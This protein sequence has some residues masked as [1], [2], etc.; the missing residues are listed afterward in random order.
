MSNYVKFDQFK[1]FINKIANKFK[2]TVET[3]KIGNSTYTPSDGLVTLPDY[4]TASG[5][6]TGIK[7]GI[8]TYTPSE[9]VITIPAYPTSL[10]ASDVFSWA[11]QS[12]KPSYTASEVGAVSSVKIGTNTYSPNSNGLVTLPTYPSSLP[13]SDVYSWAKQSTKP[14]YTATEV[15]AVSKVTVNGTTYSATNG[16]VTLPNYPTGT[17]GVTSV[18]VG[19][20][21]YEPSDGVVSLPAYPSVPTKVS[22]LQNDS[23]FTTNAGTVT[24]VKVGNTSYN[25]S[26]GVVSLPSYPSVPTKTSDLQNDNGFTSNAGTVTSVKVGI[27]NYAPVDGIVTLPWYPRKV[28]ELTNDSGFTTNEGTVTSVKVGDTTYGQSDGV[29]SLP[30][31]PSKVSDLQNDSGFTAFDRNYYSLLNR[32]YIP[33]VKIYKDY[34]R[35]GNIGWTQ[36]GN[37]YFKTFGDNSLKNYFST[38]QATNQPIVGILKFDGYVSD[39]NKYW[40][41]NL[42]ASTGTFNLYHYGSSAPTTD[43]LF[44]VVFIQTTFYDPDIPISD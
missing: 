35:N 9:G 1:T 12:S 42:N 20:T 32:P 33:R 16:T 14:S 2:G 18:K 30:A 5:G 40:I 13:A 7:V 11:K 23:G 26:S 3:I 44:Y 17:D 31:Y 41:R 6:V 28:S 34:L 10:P 37:A 4:V 29:V 19:T 38:Y 43:E 25:P 36:D 8:E 27:T 22:D 24:S 21:S 39:S 15:G